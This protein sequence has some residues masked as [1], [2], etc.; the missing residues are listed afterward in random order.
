[1]PIISRH[2]DFLFSISLLICFS[3]MNF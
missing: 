1:M 2:K 3:R